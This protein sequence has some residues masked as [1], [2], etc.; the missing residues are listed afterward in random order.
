MKTTSE[1]LAKILPELEDIF[2]DNRN[3]TP[4]HFKRLEKLGFKVIY[5]GKHPKMYINNTCI[6]LYTSASDINSG[7]QTLRRIRRVFERK[8]IQ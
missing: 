1:T 8:L 7:R 4:G 3:L 6:T 2:L 5:T